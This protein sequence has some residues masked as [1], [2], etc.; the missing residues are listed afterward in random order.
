MNIVYIVCLYFGNRRQGYN[1]EDRFHLLREHMKFLSQCND[2]DIKRAKIVINLD[3]YS[4]PVVIKDIFNEYKTPMKVDLIL[5]DNFDF[6]Y[7]AWN[8][9]II[10][11]INEYGD[12]D[13]YF[14]IEDDYLPLSKEFY[15]PFVKKINNKTKFVCCLCSKT[16]SDLKEIA[17]KHGILEKHIPKIHASISNGLLD[18]GV[19][20]DIYEKYQSIFLLTNSDNYYFADMNQ[21]I[22]LYNLTNEGFSIDDI[23]KDYALPFLQKDSIIVLGNKNG[24]VLIAPADNVDWKG[25]LNDSTI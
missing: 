14:L 9:G 11:D 6:S 25:I 20:K 18:G 15:L 10:H 16:N 1:K 3:G 21:L 5:R 17:I 13:Y 2:T 8:T 23:S 19:A 12:A 22:F 7:G 24:N 4:S